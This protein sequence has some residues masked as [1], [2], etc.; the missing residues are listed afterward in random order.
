MIVGGQHSEDM[1]R[2]SKE[3]AGGPMLLWT[4][5]GNNKK[6][7]LLDFPSNID[8]QIRNL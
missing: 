8:Q 3:S 5:P 6:T 7:N 1:M 4:V 2:Q